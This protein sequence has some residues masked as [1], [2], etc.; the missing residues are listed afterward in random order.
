MNEVIVEDEDLSQFEDTLDSYRC[1]VS[2]KNEIAIPRSYN[3]SY[4]NKNYSVNID[5]LSKQKEIDTF[6][7]AKKTLNFMRSHGLTVTEFSEKVTLLKSQKI[8]M[9]HKYQNLKFK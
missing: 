5:N 7:I 2:Q 9:S 6:L 4:S 8:D 3:H 1:D